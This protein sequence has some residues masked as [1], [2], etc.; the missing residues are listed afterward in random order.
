MTAG[1][2]V[3]VT[4]DVEDPT[5]DDSVEILW[6][7]VALLRRVGVDGAYFVTGDFARAVV[8]AG[9]DDVMGLLRGHDVGYHSNH[10]STHPTVSEY[11]E[12]AT[13][14]DGVER[15]VEHECSGVDLLRS[16]VDRPLVGFASQGTAWA[17]QLVGALGPLGLPAHVHSFSRTP[18][19]SAVHSYAGAVC[20]PRTE[21]VGPV[22]NHLHS[23]DDLRGYL[24]S[25]HGRIDAA[26]ERGAPCLQLYVGHPNYFVHEEYWD[27][28]N[29]D[30]GLNP[31]AG[32]PLRR[33]R[34]R[35]RGATSA[36]LERLE[37]FLRSVVGRPDVHVT[38]VGRLV[39][40]AVR[41][42]EADLDV[43]QAVSFAREH[44]ALGV[45]NPWASPAELLTV[46]CALH[47]GERP[48][49]GG[50]PRVLGPTATAGA[51]DSPETAGLASAE[52]VRRGCAAV[53]DHVRRTGA[54]PARVEV[55][56]RS[57]SAS[58][59]LQALVADVGTGAPELRLDVVAPYP[60]V[61]SEIAAHYAERTTHWL[62]RADL[63]PSAAA[64]LAAW[65]S[66]SLRPL[67]V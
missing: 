23:D 44:G 55:G 15:V 33:P 56:R 41:Q 38:T 9:R 28:I 64:G 13:W 49:D 46:L 52:A 29:Y 32:S 45:D 1:L 42:A 58:S 60:E 39:D 18:G 51:D 35:P 26:I 50:R 40:D 63:D 62:H 20:V 65:Q 43:E 67:P 16:L 61:G 22:E 53:T 48:L 25:V 4:L 31:A 57:V 11:C 21:F 36:M 17:P 34:A 3:Y 37:H 30:R 10:H 8:A 24:V 54:L 27:L 59:L 19:R 2:R 6:P 14:A 12:G 5:S 47:A 66:W 7:L